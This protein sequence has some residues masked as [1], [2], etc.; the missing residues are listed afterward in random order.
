MAF[1]AFSLLMLAV[2]GGA[3][4]TPENWDEMTAGKSV[5]IKFQAPW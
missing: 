3:T 2:G 5:F 1:R 4:L